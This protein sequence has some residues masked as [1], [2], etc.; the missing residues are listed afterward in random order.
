MSLLDD[1]RRLFPPR[2]PAWMTYRPGPTRQKPASYMKAG[3][4]A[5]AAAGAAA[6]GY[7]GKA[8]RKGSQGFMPSRGSYY[9]GRS[10]FGRGKIPIQK[11]NKKRIAVIARKIG[12]NEA[13][14]SYRIRSSG[15]SKTD[16]DNE[17]QYVSFSGNTA[18][19][20]VSA[21]TNLK[22]FDPANPA[23]LVTVDYNAGTF[24]KQ[25]LI[26][27][28]GNITCKNNYK[29]PVNV[30]VYLCRVRS[31]TDQSPAAA[32]TAGF[33]DIGS[34]G[35]DDPLSHAT[36]SRILTDLWH[37]KLKMNRILQPGQLYKM[38][39][40][41]K[42]F[43]Y[44]TSFVDTHSLEHVKIFNSYSWLIRIEG[45]PCHD[46]TAAEYGT[47]KCGVDIMVN[48]FFKIIYDAGV[49]LNLV[50]TEN[51]GS[52]FTNAGVVTTLDNEQNS[53]GS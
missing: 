47:Q 9:G 46:S 8:K 23:T 21:V 43:S 51:N 27:P 16:A 20:L 40:R 52:V 3:A 5:L 36:D 35:V 2:Q 19:N 28:W 48:K 17:C 6:L 32:I 42:E 14:L 50:Q 12:N 13:I 26:T 37:M 39:H 44:D 24:Q 38:S 45:T 4:V 18:A 1:Y 34:L 31:D 22:F 30:K 25:I 53:M 29:V 15:V 11:A 41:E 49:D 7:G 33:A 10:G